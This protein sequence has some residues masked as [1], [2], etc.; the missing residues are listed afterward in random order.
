[1]IFGEARANSRGYDLTDPLTLA[2]IEA[3]RAAF[4]GE[5]LWGAR[6]MTRAPGEGASRPIVNPA[7]PGEGV[8]TVFESDAGQVAAAVGM[9]VEAQADWAELPVAKRAAVLR[10]AADLYERHAVE[11]FTLATREAGKTLADAVAEVREA[12]DFLRYYADEAAA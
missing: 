7:K 3:E 2:A 6:P 4:E 12:V 9:A 8:G 11:F 10:F 1:A 5:N